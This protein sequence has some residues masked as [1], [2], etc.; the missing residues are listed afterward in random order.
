[1]NSDEITKAV[2]EFA[3]IYGLGKNREY[4]SLHSAICSASKY[5][6][7]F[8]LMGVFK[9]EMRD[10]RTLIQTFAGRM[11]LKITPKA[12]ESCESAIFSL[13]TYWDVSAE[14]VI[15]YLSD[16]HGKDRLLSVVA[17]MRKGNLPVRDLAVLKTIGYWLGKNE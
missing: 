16:Q 17:S 4:K 6:R 11:L 8:G 15:F 14:E 10:K 9:C 3:K 7:Y 1:M 13:L 2:I 5:D 12:M